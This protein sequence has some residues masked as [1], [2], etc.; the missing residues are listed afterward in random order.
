M[1][2][3]NFKCTLKTDII[4]NVKSASEG[5][6]NTL[7][8][9]P[10]SV[11]LGIVAKNY[12]S[13]RK[14]EASILFHS[15]K[16][17]FGDAHPT[18]GHVR[19]L[20]IPSQFF[21]DKIKKTDGDVYV[22]YCLNDEQHKALREKG[23]QLKQCRTGF[24]TFESNIIKEIKMQKSFAIKSAHDK[25]SLTSLDNAMYGYESLQKGATFYF[26][27]EIDTEDTYY[28]AEFC[29]VQIQKA[30]NG[31]AYIGRSRTAQYGL[32]SLEEVPSFSEY[33]S[34]ESESKL[35]TVYADGRLI[36][37]NEE[38]GQ[39]TF[40]PT[41]SQL[42]LLGGK[43]RWDLSQV[44]TFAYSPWNAKRQAFDTERCGIEKG[45][46]IVVEDAKLQSMPSYIGAY[47]NEGFGKVIYNPTFLESY[48]DG[49]SPMKFEK[50][51][52]LKDINCPILK[53]EEAESDLLYFLASREE[54]YKASA[55]V[56]EEVNKFIRTYINTF[57]DATLASQ[58][59]HIRTLCMQYHDDI[60]LSSELFAYEKGYLSH[61]VAELK[62]SDRGRRFVLKKK[63]DEILSK[64]NIPLWLFLT[65]LASQMQK[66]YRNKK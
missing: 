2:E 53:K 52:P 35:T 11:F 9:I 48:N 38:N 8:Y 33:K 18:D 27:V 6:N 5:N 54:D 1:I 66:I 10:G 47:N 62:W 32:V 44:R 25:K 58:W 43:I 4:L 19:S 64:K 13:Y 34:Q 14:E 16:V 51:Q 12:D 15:G 31:E 40:Q 28:D 37:L 50:I 23:I 56:Y 24:Y 7:D 46:V 55:A 45:S 39:P 59:G 26:T 65:N 20:R 41:V 21:V 22:H 63:C 3:L 17:R 49:V 61:G 57:K 29:K 30:L 36:F 60:Q 42:C